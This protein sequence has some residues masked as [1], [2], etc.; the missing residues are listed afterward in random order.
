MRREARS[1]E[2]PRPASG[3]QA[4]AAYALAVFA[5]GFA[6]GAV[7]VTVVE[8]AVGAAVAVAAEA[9]LMLAA[10]W[11]IC[12][13]VV[14]RA[15]IPSRRAARLAMGGWAFALLEAAETALAILAFGR[16]PGQILTAAGSVAGTIGL[17]A[18]SAFALL[19]VVQGELDARRADRRPL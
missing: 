1:A 9:P 5:V 17:A 8:P 11:F 12:R 3:W 19:P 10:S 2:A 13:A 6:I 16:S 18:Q 4:G 15:A 7:R 14:R